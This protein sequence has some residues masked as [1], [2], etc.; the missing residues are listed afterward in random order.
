[1]AEY[2]HPVGKRRGSMTLLLLL[3]T[4]L[5]DFSW[6]VIVKPEKITKCTKWS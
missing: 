4:G 1:M 2:D 3:Q 6:Y 5:P